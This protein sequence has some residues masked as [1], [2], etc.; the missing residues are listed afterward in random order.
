MISVPVVMFGWKTST[1]VSLPD[2]RVPLKSTM[3]TED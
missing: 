1:S 2:N 3:Q